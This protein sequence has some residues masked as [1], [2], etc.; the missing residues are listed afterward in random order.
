MTPPDPRPLSA[1]QVRE[2]LAYLVGN[3]EN[4]GDLVIQ[5]RVNAGMANPESIPLLLRMCGLVYRDG[6]FF[7]EG[8]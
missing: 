2:R 5:R 1:E 7:E 6:Q 4:E 3:G 8:T